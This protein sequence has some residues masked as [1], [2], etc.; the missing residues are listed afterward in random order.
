MGRPK[1]KYT[2]LVRFTIGAAMENYHGRLAAHIVRADRARVATVPT[3]IVLAEPGES[4]C[5]LLRRAE[6]ICKALKT[7]D[8]GE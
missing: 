6:I 7:A 3:L 5:S 4:R 8:L 2:Q 1:P